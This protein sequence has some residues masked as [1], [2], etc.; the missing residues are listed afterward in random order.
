MWLWQHKNI[1]KKNLLWLKIGG[2][3]LSLHL[4]ALFWV[5]CVYQENTFM[6]NFAVNRTIDYSIPIVFKLLAEPEKPSAI[7][8]QKTTTTKTV[9]KNIS[10][11]KKSVPQKTTTNTPP[12]VKPQS[13]EIKKEEKLAVETK[14]EEPVKVHP[15][16]N[17]PTPA[18]PPKPVHVQTSDNYREVEALRRTAQ[19]QKELIQQWHPPIGVPSDCVCDVSFF[20]T[21]RG[22][23]EKVTITKS[24]G[25]MMFDISTRQALFSMKMPQ[26]T[27]GKSLTISFK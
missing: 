20:V 16:K 25:I 5:F 26:W 11:P 17:I 22:I 9:A 19:L 13:T 8:M 24:S 12:L 21:K 6:H 10:Q 15:Q 3:C 14:K 18:A 1:H 27:Y 23:I 4:I 2:F 7:A